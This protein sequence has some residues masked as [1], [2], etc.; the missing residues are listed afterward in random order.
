MSDFDFV[1]KEEIKKMMDF[2]A[3]AAY[4]KLTGA[5][6]HVHVYQVSGLTLKK[7]FDLIHDNIIRENKK[8]EEEKEQTTV[9]T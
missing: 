3:G 2:F 1:K 6:K 7:E 8:A 4:S 5:A 9:T